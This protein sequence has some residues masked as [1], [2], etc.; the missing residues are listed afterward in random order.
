ML[1]PVPVL[2][3]LRGGRG[4][5]FG[6]QYPYNVKQEDKVDLMRRRVLCVT[7]I[8][9]LLQQRREEEADLEVLCRV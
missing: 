8:A 3:G 9:L 4:P 7:I 5:E 2:D 6:H 1:W